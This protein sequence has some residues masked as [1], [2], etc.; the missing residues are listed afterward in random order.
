MPPIKDNLDNKKKPTVN[1]TPTKLHSL[2]DTIENDT[3]ST[4]HLINHYSNDIGSPIDY[5]WLILWLPFL[6]YTIIM[7]IYIASITD[8][9]IKAQNESYTTE[10]IGSIIALVVMFIS[11]WAVDFI[12]QLNVCIGQKNISTTKLALNCV[13]NSI[14]VS[15]AVFL[16]YIIALGLE[17]PQIDK[18]INVHQKSWIRNLSN[19]RNN[20][21]LSTLFYIISVLYVNPITFEKK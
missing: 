13:Y 15:V 10:F 3:D 2:C 17:N 4:A 18:Q 20:F 7:L 21:V 11:R 6:I 8:V 16:G 19:H 1:T 12:Y 14:S 9:N 5:K